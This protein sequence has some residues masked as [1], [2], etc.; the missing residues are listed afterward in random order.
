[1]L[2]EKGEH[3]VGRTPVK[4]VPVAKDWAKREKPKKQECFMNA[5]KF[6]ISNL[7][8]KYYE[9]YWA[10]GCFPVWHGWVVLDGQVIDFTAEACDRY[11]KRNG[12]GRPDPAELDYF[13]VHIPTEFILKRIVADPVWSDRL[14][15]YLRSQS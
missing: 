15:E 6:C 14:S 3:F 12:M 10:S 1:V 13:G 11:C 7:D 5:Q 2:L 4:S 8:A 9:G